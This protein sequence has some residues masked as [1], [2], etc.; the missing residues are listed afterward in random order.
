[1]TYSYAWGNNP[2]REKLKGRECILL[3]RLSLGSVYIEFVDN[4]ERVVTS[5]RALRRLT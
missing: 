4:R 3:A 1:M 2:V 5:N